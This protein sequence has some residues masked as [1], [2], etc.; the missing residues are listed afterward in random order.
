MSNRIGRADFFTPVGG[1]TSS[2]MALAQAQVTEE[3]MSGAAV[4]AAKQQAAPASAASRASFFVPA[5][6]TPTA[7]QKKSVD[8]IFADELWTL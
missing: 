2:L 3:D 4:A 8:S 6:Y 1:S 7:S 5:A